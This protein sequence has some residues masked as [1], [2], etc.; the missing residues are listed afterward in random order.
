M[1]HKAWTDGKPG[2]VATMEGHL[3]KHILPRFGERPVD[4]INE[5]VVQ[6]FVADLKRTTFERRKP[7]GDADQDV[8]L[9]PQDDPQHRRRR[10]A[11]AGTEGMDDLGAGPREDQTDRSN[12][13]SRRSSCGRSS[14]R[15]RAPT[16][17][18]FA[19]LAGTGMRI[20]EAAGLHL[21][22]LDLDNG[23]IYV[24]RS[25]W[26]GQELEPKTE[27]AVREID[28]DPALVTL[29]REHIGQEPADARVR[30]SQWLAALGGQHPQ[31]RAASAL[32]QTRDP[33]GRTACVPAF[34][35]DDAAQERHAGRSAK[36]MDRSFQFEDDRPLLAHRSG[37]GIPPKRGQPR[38]AGSHCWT[39]SPTWTQPSSEGDVT[40]KATA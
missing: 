10:Q 32:E 24:R 31:P 21:D 18:L 40:A 35:G 36:A 29:L 3:A 6:E 4:A 33:E 11:G 22:D 7:N 19:L 25:V 12:G 37:T 27:N 15:H 13:T 14:K 38:R 16:G 26:N 34:A 28:I 23:V 9:E 1:N 17:S 5:T 8:P 2:P 20:G 30:G 39:Q